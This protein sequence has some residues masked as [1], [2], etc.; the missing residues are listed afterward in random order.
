MTGV[1]TC[2]LPILGYEDL[3]LNMEGLK[4][5]GEVRYLNKWISDPHSEDYDGK[6]VTSFNEVA[7]TSRKCL[8]N[9]LGELVNGKDLAVIASHGGIVESILAGALIPGNMPSKM[10]MNDY[11]GLMNMEDN[12]TITDRKSVV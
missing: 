1:Q 12:F 8:S 5:D 7:Q 6:S 2:A 11:G 10:N 9:T 4:K 3:V